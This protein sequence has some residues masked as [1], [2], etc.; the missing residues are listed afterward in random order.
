MFFIDEFVSLIIFEFELI[1]LKVFFLIDFSLLLKKRFWFLFCDGL[2]YFCFSEVEEVF[3]C[4]YILE[5]F[6]DIYFCVYYDYFGYSGVIR[7]FILFCIW[8]YWSGLFVSV[9]E[10]VW[11]CYE[12]IFGKLLLWLFVYLFGFFI[13]FYFFDV[14]YCDIFLMVFIYDFVFGCFG[15]DKLIVFVD[16]F[17]CWIEV[18]FCNGNF[19]FV[20]CLDVFMCF[21]VFC[22]GVFC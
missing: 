15:F 5:F 11:E 7:M 1:F 2:F 9:L 6:C 13:G 22:Y 17:F 16:F 19:L 10:Y 12:C 14:V 18:E 21:I 4:L 3:F 20:K 8:V